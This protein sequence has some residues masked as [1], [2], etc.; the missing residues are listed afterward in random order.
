MEAVANAGAGPTAVEPER[1]WMKTKLPLLIASLL[2][3]LISAPR[4]T[5]PADGNRTADSNATGGEEL[6]FGGKIVTIS[7]EKKSFQVF[8]PGRQ[9]R[10]T[11]LVD[12]ESRL[13]GLELGM[14]VRV[15]AEKSRLDPSAFRAREIW[16]RGSRCM[17]DPTGVRTRMR[18]GWR[19]R[20]GQG[21][22]NGTANGTVGPQ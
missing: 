16:I 12:D 4:T 6:M 3:L 2:L 7:L 13:K 9:R 5:L 8:C 21:S 18:R 10:F 11:V 17:C 14:R 22:A 19:W 15:R 20:W 1:P